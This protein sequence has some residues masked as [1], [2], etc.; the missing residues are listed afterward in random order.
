MS[1]V[2][3]SPK[4][5]SPCRR[6]RITIMI[7]SLSATNPPRLREGEFMLKKN[8]HLPFYSGRNERPRRL[9]FGIRKTG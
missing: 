6:V 3:K 5:S 7:L 9:D 8:T 1:S 4:K 2:G